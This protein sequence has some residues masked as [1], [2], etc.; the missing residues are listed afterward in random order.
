MVQKPAFLR[1]QTK[2]PKAKNIYFYY[3]EQISKKCCNN[4]DDVGRR[5]RSLVK[6]NPTVLHKTEEIPTISVLLRRKQS[7]PFAVTSFLRL[8]RY[9][10]Q[11]QPTTLQLS[12]SERLERAD[13]H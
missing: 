9:P 5:K 2:K 3:A 6:C 7:Q 4:T 8:T 13:K 1:S 12:E 10:D 11:Y